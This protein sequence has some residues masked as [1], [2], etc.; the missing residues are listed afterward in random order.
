MHELAHKR[1]GDIGLKPLQPLEHCIEGSRLL[2]E[3]GDAAW[4]QR[5]G[6]GDVERGD[7]NRAGAG[8]LDRPGDAAAEID[9]RQDRNNQQ[10][11][12]GQCRAANDAQVPFS[13]ELA[14]IATRR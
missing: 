3:L 6:V 11:G 4:R 14:F 7:L 5:P 2:V 9:R 13:S 8:A 12:P 10:S 1:L